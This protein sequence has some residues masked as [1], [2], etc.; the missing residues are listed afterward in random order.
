MRTRTIA[1]L[2]I[3]SVLVGMVAAA[4]TANGAAEPGVVHFTAAGDYAATT[5]T[6]TVLDR[7][8]VQAPDLNLALGDLSYGTTG[9]EQQWCDL[10]TSRVGA[11]FPFELLSGNHES[12]GQNGN[13]NDFS[14]CLPNQ[15]PGLVG[16]YGRQW[17]VDVPR[18]NPLVRIVMISP[19]LT[20][21][22][23]TWSYAV[24]TPRYQWT[25]A[26]IDGARAAA[27]PW[28]VVGVHKPCL[29]LGQYGCD[30]GADLTN[31]LITKKV[32]LV[33][34]GHEHGY[35]RTK[36]LGAGTGCTA[37][38][39]GSF[40]AACVLDS[41]ND[42]VKGRGT[43]FATVGTGG[44]PLRDM[45]ATDAEAGYFASWSGLNANPTFGLLD[46]RATAD[47][48]DA[49]FIGTSGGTFADAFVI[50]RDT[51]TNQ[52][53]TAAFLSSSSGL[54][55]SFDGSGSSDVDGAV[56]SYAWSFGDGATGTGVQPSHSYAAAGSYSVTLTVT[57]DKGA[58]ASV[59]QVVTV[60]G[61][62]PEPAPFVSDSFARTVSSGLGTADLGGVWST[63]GTAS[64]FS[65]SA[66]AA[67]LALR[68]PGTQ[69]SAYLGST[70]RNDTDLRLTLAADKVATGG[71]LYL[72]VVGRRVSLNNEYFGRVRIDATG[73]VR[74]SLAA[75]KGTSTVTTIQPEIALPGI[76]YTPN[77]QLA[78]RLQVT[79]T[80]PS[81]LR[82]KV[83]PASAT[84]PAAW[85]MSA[86]DTTAALQAPGAVGLTA[87]LSSSATNAP[88]VV[89]M[90]ALTARPT[91][92]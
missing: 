74:I 22:D 11:G 82:L 39:P 48:L 18:Q 64:N 80:G 36:Q 77:L 2:T 23:G 65:V 13:I 91:A 44:V 26:A 17:Y 86:S 45:N 83:W 85:Q 25:A 78:V 63:G 66:G 12:N 55:A 49:R 60:G 52:P 7:M 14:A 69:L 84:E 28:V 32:D 41:D 57:D 90:S 59:T 72:N 35:Q 73:S 16:T 46:V 71:G 50:R 6:R 8:A 21:P 27:V 76:T 42:L 24:G 34:H 29:S 30:I 5:A 62:T 15:L 1:K 20:Y 9:A 61:G 68:T 70:T 37:V 3:A 67:A 43:I 58:T 88:V 79:G 47:Q 87:Y 40:N 81:T 10:V 75:L 56:A 89:R 31:L 19:G 92:A 51:T 54:T 53:P 4:G 33:L 38:Q